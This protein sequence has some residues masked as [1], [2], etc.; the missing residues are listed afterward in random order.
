MTTVSSRVLRKLSC[1][2]RRN[3][4]PNPSTATAAISNRTCRYKPSM[5]SEAIQKAIIPMIMRPKSTTV[6]SEAYPEL[7]LRDPPSFAER[8]KREKKLNIITQRMIWMSYRRVPPLHENSY[9]SAENRCFEK[10][11]AK[12]V[13]PR[14]LAD[15]SAISKAKVFRLLYKRGWFR[16]NKT[17]ANAF[18]LCHTLSRFAFL[19]F[20]PNLHWI[21]YR[22]NLV[23][24]YL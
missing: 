3:A 16:T 9:E 17:R 15:I 13:P 8:R 5:T 14:M 6:S 4:N 22:K 18:E 1:A 7:T 24:L 12:A 21:D 2:G 10:H 19:K 20:D 11:S 23:F